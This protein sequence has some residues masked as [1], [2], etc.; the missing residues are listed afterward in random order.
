MVNAFLPIKTPRKYTIDEFKVTFTGY[1]TGIVRSI[2]VFP[3]EMTETFINSIF[4][5]D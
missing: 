2:P 1:T 4:L 5:N 3:V